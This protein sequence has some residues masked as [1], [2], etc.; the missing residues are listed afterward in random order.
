MEVINAISW[1]SPTT[2]SIF[3]LLDKDYFLGYYNIGSAI[4]YLAGVFILLKFNFLK[5][6]KLNLNLMRM[7]HNNILYGQVPLFV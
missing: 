7:A 5:M 1:A 2:Y 4:L 6:G 3:F